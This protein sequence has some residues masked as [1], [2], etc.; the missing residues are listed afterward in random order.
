MRLFGN[1]AE[2]TEGTPFILVDNPDRAGG[3]RADDD[4]EGYADEV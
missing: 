2:D 4:H 3:F 1:L